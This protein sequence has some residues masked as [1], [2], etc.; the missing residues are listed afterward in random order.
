MFFKVVVLNFLV[1]LKACNFIEKETPT[2]VFSCEYCEIFKNTFLYRTTHASVSFPSSRIT[3]WEIGDEWFQSRDCCIVGS[4]WSKNT[5]LST[6]THF[7]P[8]FPFYTL[9][10]YQKIC[11]V[12]YRN[13]SFVLQSKTNDWFL[14]ETQ[15][16][17]WYFQG[18]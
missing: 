14:Y 5:S 8:V 17:F 10:K 13:Q 16:V 6:L 9:W 12:S 2:Q 15:Q 18:V 3:W 11:S 4:W 7:W 1:V